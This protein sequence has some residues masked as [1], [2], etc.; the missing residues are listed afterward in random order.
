[1]A[2]SR[3]VR[4]VNIFRPVLSNWAFF[5]PL[6]VFL[7][8][9]HIYYK[10][11]DKTSRDVGSVSTSKSLIN[12]S[13]LTVED[14]AKVFAKLKGFLAATR[15]NHGKMSISSAVCVIDP[16][17]TDCDDVG[18]AAFLLSTL[19]YITRCHAL[20]SD[21]PVVFWRACN[22]ACSRDRRVNSWNWYFKPL[23]RGLE[24]QA[25]R[26]L[27]PFLFS[28]GIKDSFVIDN[29]LNPILDNSQ[30]RIDQNWRDTKTAE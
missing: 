30:L 4:R 21:R 12:A 10:S 27:C 26:V 23:N 28:D 8:L 19:D 5:L 29:H 22:S 20:G 11:P 16:T 24:S 9:L 17:I 7:C 6:V 13:L 1:M 18:F 3:R 2:C 15:T 14:V 25:E